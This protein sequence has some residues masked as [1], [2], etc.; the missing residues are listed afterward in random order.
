MV[1][2]RR[3]TAYKP[4]A[5]HYGHYARQNSSLPGQKKH[6]RA[7]KRSARASTAKRQSE[8]SLPP[9]P[10]PTPPDPTKHA[11]T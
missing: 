8:A 9:P 11:E 4:S 7:K 6:Q 10:P 1:G 2:T 3:G 5:E